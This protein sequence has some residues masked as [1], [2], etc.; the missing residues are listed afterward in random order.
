[1]KKI[2]PEKRKLEDG[3][4]VTE[5]KNPDLVPNKGAFASCMIRIGTNRLLTEEEIKALNDHLIQF[6]REWAVANGL[7]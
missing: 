7:A 6:A 5:W 1:M 2:Q 4:S 3:N